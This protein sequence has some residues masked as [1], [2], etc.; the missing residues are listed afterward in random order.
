[1]LHDPPPTV[2]TWR[3]PGLNPEN[4]TKAN[5]V[6]RFA[7]AGKELLGGEGRDLGQGRARLRASGFAGADLQ[8]MGDGVSR[9]GHRLS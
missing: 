9:G 6:F 1:M 4:V 2:S 5:S 7:R 3:R 8:K